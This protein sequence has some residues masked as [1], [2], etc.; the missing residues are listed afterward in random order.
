MNMHCECLA[1]LGR[2]E[3]RKLKAENER[4]EQECSEL[5]AAL[6]LMLKWTDPTQNSR[7]AKGARVHAVLV[8]IDHE[9][10]GRLS[11]DNGRL[12]AMC[13]ELAA[14]IEVLRPCVDTLVIQDKEVAR[15]EGLADNALARYRAMVPAMDREPG[16]E[17]GPR[18][19]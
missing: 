15:L 10:H 4:L 9:K 11:A 7:A 14:V 6:E 13:E 19:Y 1:R 16:G 2:C 12:R 18:T 3:A 8:L 5:W 17:S